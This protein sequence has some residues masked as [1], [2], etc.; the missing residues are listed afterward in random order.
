MPISYITASFK[1]FEGENF[2]FFD[3]LIWIVSPVAGFRPCRAFL[4]AILKIP[5]PL[6]L[7]FPP[8]FIIFVI[9]SVYA[10]I[11]SSACFLEISKRVANSC[12]NWFFVV[13]G[14]DP[15]ITFLLSLGDA[16]NFEQRLY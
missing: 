8:A 5:K 11:N 10:S 6:M 3:A 15:A 4:K 14:C 9:S 1:A 16:Q 13:D 2:G 7:T 12:A